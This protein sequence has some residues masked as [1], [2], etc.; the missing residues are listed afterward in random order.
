MRTPAALLLSFLLV[1][2]CAAGRGPRA[3]RRPQAPPTPQPH[4]TLTQLQE[5]VRTGNRRNEWSVLS[6]GFKQRLSAR[7]G[8]TIDLA[9]YTYFRDIHR[10]NPQVREAESYLRGANISGV[11]QIGPGRA[12]VTIW[13][14]GPL[15]FGRAVNVQM[16]HLS[17]W[18][19]RVEGERDPYWGFHG[20]DSI[21]ARSD[22]E[23]GYVVE[24]RA[25]N[26][27]VTWSEAI[28][29]SRVRSFAR[30]TA[31]YFDHLGELEAYFG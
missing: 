23:G 3:P 22:G 2:G 14:G 17:R 20:D 8:R 9:D 6:P 12:R 29:A 7:I 24:T 4:H 13:F 16:I 31:W 18:E 10:R 5:A 26:G 30:R 21:T 1:F 11:R 15:F 25:P 19:L 27:E 28:P